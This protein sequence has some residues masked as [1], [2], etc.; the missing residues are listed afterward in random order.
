MVQEKYGVQLTSEDHPVRAPS[1]QGSD[2]GSEAASI[3]LG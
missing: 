1:E 2:S 3:R